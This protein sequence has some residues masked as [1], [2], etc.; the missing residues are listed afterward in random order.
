MCGGARVVGE[1]KKCTNVKCRIVMKMEGQNKIIKI[2]YVGIML[3][4]SSPKF[5]IYDKNH[6][7]P[8]FYVN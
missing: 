5:I 7:P 2:I 4:N 1:K 3:I 8:H 6:N